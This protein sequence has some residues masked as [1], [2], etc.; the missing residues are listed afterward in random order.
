[1]NAFIDQ[2]G[3]IACGPKDQEE[4]ART[5]EQGCPTS[6]ISLSDTE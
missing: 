2:D 1:M 3:C 4:S 6:V 5:A